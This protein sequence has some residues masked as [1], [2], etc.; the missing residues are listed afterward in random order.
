MKIVLSRKGFDSSS[1]GIPNV[2]LPDNSFLVFPIPDDYSGIRYSEI[3]FEYKHYKNLSQVLSDLGNTKIKNHYA[4]LDPDM[5][6]GSL[7]RKEGWK[8]L[9]GQRDSSLS[10]LLKN[11]VRVGDL[12]LFFATF[13]K[14][15]YTGCNLTFDKSDKPRHI[16]YGYFSIGEYVNLNNN[17]KSDSKVCYDWGKYHPHYKKQSNKNGI[18]V[19]S[20][21]L[22]LNGKKIRKAGA[23]IFEKYRAELLLTC[24]DEKKSIWKLPTFFWPDEK[25]K[26]SLTYHKV[27]KRWKRFSDHLEL[28]SVG[29][30]QEFVLDIGDNNKEAGA[31]LKWLLEL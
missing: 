4:H 21:Y 3:K 27:E 7:P 15:K 16:I 24:S 29:R 13:Q 9:F 17:V 8:P 11:G 26:P 22:Q 18:F 19:S 30:G 12:F 14:T 6:K 2:I 28:Q 5:I 23:S 10:H 1:G 25:I 20:D 31:W